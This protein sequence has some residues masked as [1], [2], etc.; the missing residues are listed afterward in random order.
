MEE[1]GI[2]SKFRKYGESFTAG[3][4]S[5]LPSYS[6]EARKQAAEKVFV[7]PAAQAMLL[8]LDEVEQLGG[9]LNLEDQLDEVRSNLELLVWDLE[10]LAEE[11]MLSEEISSE[12]DLD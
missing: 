5:P 4:S 6:R 11:G 10:E 12:E 3:S 7:L 1:S 9:V 8:T 2:G